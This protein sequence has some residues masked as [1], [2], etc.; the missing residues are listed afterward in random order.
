MVWV[1]CKGKGGVDGS[2]ALEKVSY[3]FN[4]LLLSFLIR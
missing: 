3:Q 2:N 4:S 1:E